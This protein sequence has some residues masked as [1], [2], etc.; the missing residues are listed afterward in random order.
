MMTIRPFSSKMHNVDLFSSGEPSLDVFLK[1]QASQYERRNVGRTYVATEEPSPNVSGYYTIAVGALKLDQLAEQSRKNLP[2][3]DVPVALL[4]RL[5]VDQTQQG[6]GLG[7]TLLRDALLRIVTISEQIGI[8]AI[9]VDALHD[10]AKN[11]Y[12]K[13]SFTPCVDQPLRLYLPVK[14]ISAQ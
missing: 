7:A 14:S 2:R 10:K 11:Y 5:A 3:H 6:K 8:H 4:G 13:Y 9:V 12:L 1:T